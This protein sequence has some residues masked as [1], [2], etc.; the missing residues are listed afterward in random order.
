MVRQVLARLAEVGLR[1][2]GRELVRRLGII[3]VNSRLRT[4]SRSDMR[5]L[6]TD[7]GGWWVPTDLLDDASVCYL[8]GV[9]ED[10]SFDLA[11]VEQFGCHVVA[12]DPTP[13]SAAHVADMHDKRFQFVPLGLWSRDE[14]LKFYKPADPQHVSHSV[15]NIQGTESGFTAQ[16]VTVET[17]QAMLGYDRMDLLKLDIEGAETAV[18]DAMLAGSVRP[19]ILC[20]E[21][22]AIEN[23][24][25]TMARVRRLEAVGYR[26]CRRE[27]RNYTFLRDGVLA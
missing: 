2:F 24:W 11:L 27:G 26:C 14:E 25:R 23:A 21:F 22:D 19:R 13:R 3:V 4:I 17:L 16:C 18:L 5:R 10:I 15:M 1:R 20:V 6:G 9:G 8:A 7:Y 12:I